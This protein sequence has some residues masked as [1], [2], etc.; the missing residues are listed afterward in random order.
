VS[1]GSFLRPAR[2]REILQ[3]PNVCLYYADHKNATGYVALTGRAVLVNDMAEIL[4]RKR[5]Y[6]DSSF[7][8]GLKNLVLIKV[9]AEQLDVQNYKQDALNDPQ[10]WRTPPSLLEKVEATTNAPCHQKVLRR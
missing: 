1:A 7:E 2:A 8:A 10:T 3:N 5:A 4:K 9:I 6:W